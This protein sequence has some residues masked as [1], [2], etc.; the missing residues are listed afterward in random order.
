VRK[1]LSDKTIASLKPTSKRYEIRDAHLPGFGVRVSPTGRKSLFVA[2][3]YGTEQRRMA[4][5]RYP[6]VTLA[7]AREKALD[8]LRHV[9]EGI[10]PARVHRVKSHLICAVVDEFIEKYAKVKTKGWKATHS[11]L[12]RE[13]VGPFGQRDIR[14]LQRSDII[15]ILDDMVARGANAQANRFLAHIRK[16]L[17]WCVERGIVESSPANGIKAQ[18]KEVARERVLSDEELARLIPACKAAGYP[19]GD[20]FLTMLLTAQRRGEV[21]G[22]RWSEL[23]LTNR[24]W[25]LPSHRVKNARPHTV[26]LSASVL[27]ILGRVPRFLNSDFVFTTTGHSG[28]SGWGKPFVRLCDSAAVH[29]WRLHDLR[30]TAASGMAR[31]GVPPHVVEKVL[32]HISGTISGV[33]AVYNRYG[34]DAEKRDALEQWGTLIESIQKKAASD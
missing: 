7:Q 31:H 33:A 34:Y 30:R 5:G 8:A 22:M 20:L 29:E 10:D 12:L 27:R 17:N 28:V 23:D 26:P 6:R 32:N 4:L 2:Y 15:G 21:S 24:V 19:F 11:L 25:N 14:K 18:C 3:R 9:D 13:V 16:M 1:A